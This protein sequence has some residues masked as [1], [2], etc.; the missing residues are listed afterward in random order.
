MPQYDPNFKKASTGGTTMGPCT[1]FTTFPIHFCSFFTFEK[2]KQVGSD[3]RTDGQT[4]RDARMHLKRPVG[5]LRMR[6]LRF[7]ESVMDGPTDR[8]T[9]RWTDPLIG[10]LRRIQKSK[11]PSLKI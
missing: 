4:L 9:D 2:K 3:R 11:P 7:D 5:Q 8:Q 10:M 6:Q 1:G